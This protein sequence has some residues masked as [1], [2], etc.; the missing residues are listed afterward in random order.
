MVHRLAIREADD[1]SLRPP[2]ND[3]ADVQC[4]RAGS[5]SGR[6]EPGEWLRLG[7]PAVDERLQPL[8]VFGSD[9][10]RP[11]SE[12]GASVL[13]RRQVRADG[14]Q[15]ELDAPQIVLKR[16]MAKERLGPAEMRVQLVHRAVSLHAEIAFGEPL[17]A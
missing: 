15:V 8:R 17:A 11:G 3:A 1:A 16:E 2:A 7:I 14:E 9:P 12:A 4:R 10:D 6:D 13:R 5:A